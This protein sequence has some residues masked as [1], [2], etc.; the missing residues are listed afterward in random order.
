MLEERQSYE[1]ASQ[2]GRPRLTPLELKG[3]VVDEWR[4]GWPRY[5]VGGDDLVPLLSELRGQTVRLVIDAESE[6]ALG[7]VYREVEERGDFEP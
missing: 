1:K 2:E 5:S 6:C 7:A 3:E 4:G